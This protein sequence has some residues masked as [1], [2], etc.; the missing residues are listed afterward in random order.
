MN[1]D[2]FRPGTG[3]EFLELFARIRDS[4]GLGLILLNPDDALRAA[5]VDKTA[6]L[7]DVFTAIKDEPWIKPI[8]GC[9]WYALIS[10]S[11]GVYTSDASIIKACQYIGKPVLDSSGGGSNK[12]GVSAFIS[13]AG[14]HVDTT[15]SGVDKLISQLIV[16]YNEDTSALV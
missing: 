13:A 9:H 10:I 1:R 12:D 5:S 7:I 2:T 3:F 6:C 14:A 11:S 8:G 16:S 4:E 15:G